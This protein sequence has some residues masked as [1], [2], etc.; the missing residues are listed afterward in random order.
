MAYD[1]RFFGHFIL[2]LGFVLLTFNGIFIIKTR[3]FT[4][5]FTRDQQ[6]EGWPAV[7]AGFGSVAMGLWCFWG[8]V[9][10][11]MQHYQFLFRGL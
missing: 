5:P 7:L 9:T 8:L 11:F 1:A 10:A 3:N 6:V 2:F 4:M